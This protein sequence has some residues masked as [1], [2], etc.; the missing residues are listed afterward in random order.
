MLDGLVAIAKCLVSELRRLQ[1]VEASTM[2]PKAGGRSL[3]CTLLVNGHVSWRAT[4]APILQLAK[5]VWRGANTAQP[6]GLS[7]SQLHRAWQAVKPQNVDKWQNVRGP[8]GAHTMSLRRLGWSADGPFQVTT[9]KGR[10]LKFTE[11]SPKMVALEIQA[12]AKR[13]PNSKTER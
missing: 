2:S 4:A 11:T 1:R 6:R 10:T 12:A 13:Q 5:A 9:D 3:S 7:L 8:L